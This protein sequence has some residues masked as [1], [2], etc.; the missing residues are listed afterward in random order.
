MVIRRN[1]NYRTVVNYT[2]FD[3]NNMLSN[4][5]IM[6]P[7]KSEKVTNYNVPNNSEMRNTSK[8]YPQFKLFNRY[9]YLKKL[10]Q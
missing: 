3:N 6:V 4:L 2:N 8:S 1:L 5:L 7:N 9:I 10:L